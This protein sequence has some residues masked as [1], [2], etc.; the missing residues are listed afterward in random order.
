MSNSVTRKQKRKEE[1]EINNNTTKKRRIETLRKTESPMDIDTF[2]EYLQSQASIKQQKKKTKKQP[3]DLQSLLKKKQEMERELLQFE[4]EEKI[5]GKQ[6]EIERK[7]EENKIVIQ[8]LNEKIQQEK[9]QQLIQ[10]T[11]NI[12]EKELF[13]NIHTIINDDAY[14]K[15]QAKTCTTEFKLKEQAQ[16]EFIKKYINLSIN[17]NSTLQQLNKSIILWHGLGSGKTLTSIFASVESIN[18]KKKEKVNVLLPASLQG[19]F[20]NEIDTYISNYI[21]ENDCKEYCKS[22]ASSSSPSLSL[23]KTRTNYKSNSTKNKNKTKKKDTFLNIKKQFNKCCLNFNF[24]TYNGDFNIERKF[25]TEEDLLSGNSMHNRFNKSIIIVDESQLFIS[26]I[27]KE[28]KNETDNASKRIYKFLSTRNNDNKNNIQIILLSGTPI[29]YDINEL[30]I[31]FNVL[32]GETIF[33]V[34]D[35]NDGGKYGLLDFKRN[36][37]IYNNVDRGADNKIMNIQQINEKRKEYCISLLN[38]EYVKDPEEIKFKIYGLLSFFGNIETMLPKIKLLDNCRIGYNNEGKAFYSIKEC[39]MTNEQKNNMDILR[40]ILE[41]IK[42]KTIT[43]TD[44]IVKNVEQGDDNQ[45]IKGQNNFLNIIYAYSN[46]FAYSV[47]NYDFQ[48]NNRNFNDFKIDKTERTGIHSYQTEQRTKQIGNLFNVYFNGMKNLIE[49][50]ENLENNYYLK[51]DSSLKDF[52]IKMHEIVECIRNNIDK[53]HLIYCESRRINV[54]LV[55]YLSKLL[56]YKEFKKEEEFEKDTYYYMFLTGQQKNSN[57]NDNEYINFINGEGQCREG[58]EKNIKF[59]NNQDYTSK[60]NVIIINSASAEGITLKRINYVHFLEIPP[61]ISRLL[62]IIGRAV[63]NCTHVE[64]KT[65]MLTDNQKEEF[66]KVTPILYLAVYDPTK[67]TSSSN[68]KKIE[69]INN[70]EKDI[71]KYKKC[72]NNHEIFLPYLQLLK[73]TS[74]DCF[75]NQKINPDLKCYT[76]KFTQ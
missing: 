54:T 56:Q 72:I 67:I 6:A 71:I 32:K 23:S 61:N 73:E 70:N 17:T 25:R 31:L 69:N 75:M 24:Y 20:T 5:I 57:K 38:S 30:V 16:Q 27:L 63:R 26:K 53:K 52:S 47:E 74:V 50:K 35:F 7:E 37:F 29:I 12:N 28:I 10:I 4:K 43:D 11:E 60:L 19:N 13:Q 40:I 22:I 1:T 21:D 42:G 48:N 59:F 46:I 36:T 55:R 65:S 41:N 18:K 68:N 9:E 45:I 62:Q 2:I 3:E 76:D 66:Y 34:G 8:K 44:D 51:E 14:V 64:Y 49:N 33:N 39:F 15:E 58:K